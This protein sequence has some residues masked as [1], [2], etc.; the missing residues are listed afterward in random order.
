MP[1]GDDDIQAYVD[2]RLT[3]ERQRIVEAYF[4]ANPVEHVR[5]EAMRVDL[6]QLRQR[7]AAKADE[8]IPAH[9]RVEA[10]KQRMATRR[11][12]VFR[13][14]AA[15]IV[16]VS[17][18]ALAGWML[19]SVTA[20][21]EPMPLQVAT[22]ASDA[23]RTFVVEVVHPVEVSAADEGHLIKWLSNRTGLSLKPPDLSEFGYT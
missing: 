7:L 12:L 9:L 23:Y 14:V 1:I 22:T 20:S 16:L 2:G 21:Y 15:T 11:S 4:K 3:A 8:P 17:G 10:I 13:Q 18:G 6:Q 5:I 19:K